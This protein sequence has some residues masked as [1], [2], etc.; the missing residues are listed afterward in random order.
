MGRRKQPAELFDEADFVDRVFAYILTML[1]E[2][3]GREGDIKRSLREE[4]GGGTR[5]YVR[6]YPERERV[7][8]EVSRMFDG[9]NATQIARVLGISRATVYR[10]LKQRGGGPDIVEQPDPL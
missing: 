2:L 3:A 10:H 6:R 7:R 1:P 9:R 8:L 4:F 5:V